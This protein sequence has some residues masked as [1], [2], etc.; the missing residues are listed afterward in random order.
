[1]GIAWE[2]W[3]L[4]LDCLVIS[5]VIIVI[6]AGR[7]GTVMLDARECKFDYR[8]CQFHEKFAGSLRYEDWIMVT[9]SDPFSSVRVHTSCRS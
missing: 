4:A 9:A 7:D 2:I 8:E 3:F 6:I 1:M 5:I